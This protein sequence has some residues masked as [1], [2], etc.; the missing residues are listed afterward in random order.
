LE[1]VG[2]ARDFVVEV[3]ADL[4]STPI[5]SSLVADV[6][7]A[8]SELVTNAVIHGAAP[9]VL[10]IEL[11]DSAVIC[12]VTSS[13]AGLLAALATELAPPSTSVRSGRGLLIV[14]AVADA[15]QFDADGAT[16]SVTCTFLVR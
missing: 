3:L 7:L 1:S 13:V 2:T 5:A 10:Q 9:I 14:N 16:W 11:T 4:A 8:V 6:Q 12:T 15:V